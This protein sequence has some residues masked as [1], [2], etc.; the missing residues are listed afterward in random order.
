MSFRYHKR[1]G[2]AKAR[3]IVLSLLFGFAILSGLAPLLHAHD[4]DLN[5]VHKDCITCHWS[6]S[7]SGVENQA[8]DL[9]L[10]SSIHFLDTLPF[11]IFTGSSLRALNN[12]GPP[13]IL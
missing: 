12:R 4:F 5:H 9:P 10:P 3:L 13:S 2:P 8:T 7:H 11:E 6:Q 1:S